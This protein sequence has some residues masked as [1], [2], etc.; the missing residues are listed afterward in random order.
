MVFYTG[1]KQSKMN[2][3][4]ELTILVTGSTMGSIGFETALKLASFGHKLI[5][6][7][8]SIEKADLAAV[9]ICRETNGN[10]P[11]TYALDLS[12]DDS[13]NMFSS[14]LISRGKTLNIL[15]NNAGF[16]KT[17][18]YENSRGIEMSMAV[19]Y[20][21]TRALTTALL[22]LLER[23]GRIINVT[24]SMASRG[25]LD[26]ENLYL[27]KNWSGFQAYFNSKFAQ[28][29]YTRELAEELRDKEIT[30]NA[31]H[32]G[33]IITNIWE[34]LW[35][36]N[37]ILKR[38]IAL[39]ER[40]GFLSAYRGARTPVFLAISPQVSHGTDGYYIHCKLVKW[41]SNCRNRDQNKA[42]IQK[43]HQYHTV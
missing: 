9:A 23:G 22:P 20:F 38:L 13:I 7:C 16:L 6:T 21:G 27:E 18:R 40:T 24:S 35:P 33:N 34:E 26:F 42:I 11:E 29:L 8:R 36:Y 19:N 2:N 4:D 3:M 41:P 17:R 10:R 43:L 15:I 12:E 30:V 1:G 25:F 5:I 32:P 31:L 39:I 14:S 28:N 37:K